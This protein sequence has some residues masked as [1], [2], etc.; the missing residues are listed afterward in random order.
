M[1]V[2]NVTFEA[3]AS[4]ESIVKFRRDPKVPFSISLPFGIMI[5]KLRPFIDAYFDEKQ[6]LYE[7]YCDKDEKG[8]KIIKD[9]NIY[10]SGLNRDK[11]NK[12]INTLVNAMVE[13]DGTMTAKLRIDVSKLIDG[14]SVDDIIA[15]DDVVEFYDG[16]ADKSDKDNCKRK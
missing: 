9:G 7:K 15:L 16:T 14:L 12:D 13:L 10:F 5:G 4:N 6:K 2:R 1:K 3:V 11:L 8:E